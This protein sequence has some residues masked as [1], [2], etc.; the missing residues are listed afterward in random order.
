MNIINRR[1]LNREF[2]EILQYGCTYIQ[3]PVGYG[4]TTCLRKFLSNHRDLQYL[5][6][7]MHHE[8]DEAWAW[9]KM[10]KLLSD[11]YPDVKSTLSIAGLPRTRENMEMIY[12]ALKEVVKEPLVF[13]IDDCNFTP[14]SQIEKI[15]LNT[16]E[17]EIP[18]LHFVI[19]SREEPSNAMFIQIVERNILHI[20]KEHFRFTK[21][22]IR[23][24]FMAND[25]ELSEEE[26]NRME[27]YSEGWITALLLIYGNHK[28]E[29]Y[30]D[31]IQDLKKL[32][33]IS[34]YD[35][36]TLV[37]QRVLM[38]LCVLKQFTKEQANF[39]TLS[40]KT[41]SYIEQLVSMRNFVNYDEGSAT[42]RISPVLRTFLEEEL[43]LSSIDVKKLYNRIAQWYLLNGDYMNA[44][45]AY[46]QANE[47]ARI[48]ELMET[49][50]EENYMDIIPSFIDTI[51]KKIPLNIKLKYPYAYLH[52]IHDVIM[53]ISV[54]KGMVLFNEFIS[55]VESGYFKEE[56]QQLQ[57]E[58]EL[59]TGCI[60]YN[61]LRAMGVYFKK[62]YELLNKNRSKVSN[63]N[64]ITTFGAYEMLYL[65]HIQAGDLQAL[66]EDINEKT[67]YYTY[68]TRGGNAGMEAQTQAELALLRG[69]YERVEALAWEAY[70]KAIHYKQYSVAMCSLFTLGRLAV[71]Q[72]NRALFKQINATLQESI[73]REQI[74]ITISEIECILASL[75]MR[76]GDYAKVPTWIQTGKLESCKLLYECF[77]I[78]YLVY[79]EYLL[80]KKEY[81]KLRMVCTTLKEMY[82]ETYHILGDIA[83]HIYECVYLY[84]EEKEQAFAKL[85]EAIA[86]AKEDGI[87]M[88]FVEKAKVLLPIL[89]AYPNKDAFVEKIVSYS[90]Q[91]LE[92]MDTLVVF[93]QDRLL[94]KRENEIL[95]YILQD[96]K[97]EEIAE[98]LNVSVH[99]VHSHYAKIFQKL[100]ANSTHDLIRKYRK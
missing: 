51:L 85:E 88:P 60:Q 90:E 48:L 45:Y 97:R 23:Y 13:V 11:I 18:N 32:I 35:S 71:A 27:E 14:N 72:K 4:K 9:N 31:K 81:K 33:R 29:V 61:D 89:Q 77:S 37:Q 8:N 24:L 17:Y 64:Q 87:I 2:S 40:D 39:I 21:E 62:A 1:D 83:V 59:T 53:N 10:T 20:N 22:E 12:D 6:F 49:N 55:Y 34:F 99:T 28:V 54:E 82:K 79:G 44:I 70:A 57:G 95:S 84:K 73:V 41:S 46:D 100:R 94:T 69:E 96:Y 80:Y 74:P 26:L 86:L 56:T 3:A 52:Y 63:C 66:V 19:V 47:Y 78:S 42:Y 67:K 7:S 25:C 65:Y 93:E 75:A 15:I 30:P 36:L 38:K 91:Y 68:I 50:Y 43:S 58:I 5:Y 16:I 92:D 98:L 76:I